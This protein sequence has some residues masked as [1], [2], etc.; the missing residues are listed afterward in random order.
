MRKCNGWFIILVMILPIVAF[1]SPIL[2]KR[3]IDISPDY[4]D[5]DNLLANMWE[6]MYKAHGVGLA[7]PP[8]SPCPAVKAVTKSP[9]S[10][11]DL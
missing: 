5:L 7:A 4:P 6:T 1:G 2:R 10:N 3:C 8:A 11:K 9:K